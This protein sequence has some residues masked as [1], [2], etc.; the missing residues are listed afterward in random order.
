MRNATIATQP[1]VGTMLGL[2]SGLILGTIQTASAQV[3]Q[4]YVADVRERSGLMTRSAPILPRLPVD[5]DRDVFH[6]TRWRDRNDPVREHRNSF[7][8]GGMYGYRLPADCTESR[9]PFFRGAPGRSTLSPD[10]T[11]PHKFGRFFSALTHPYKP[12]GYYYS[13][14]SYVPIY[15]LDPLVPGPGPYPW[16]VFLKQPT[17]G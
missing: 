9:Y 10:C 16:S 2:L 13:R 12:V 1:R 15:D 8:D 17:G 3:P 5:A 7:K 4:P 6:D 11:P 14:G